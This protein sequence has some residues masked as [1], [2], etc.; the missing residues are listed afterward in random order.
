MSRGLTWPRLGGVMDSEAGPPLKKHG[1]GDFFK[2]ACRDG[3][4]VLEMS[5]GLTWPRLGGVMDSE[6][7]VSPEKIRTG[8]TLSGMHVATIMTC[9]RCLAV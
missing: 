7:E 9:L 2:H 6:A 4:D 3:H 5:C 8:T 1:R